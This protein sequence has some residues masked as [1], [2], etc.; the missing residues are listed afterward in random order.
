MAIPLLQ[1]V[2]GL[3]EGLT[4]REVGVIGAII[5]FIV[6][7]RFDDLKKAVAWIFSVFV[8]DVADRREAMQKDKS[9]E[10][11]LELNRWEFQA[12]KEAT[13]E[14]REWSVSQQAIQLLQGQLDFYRTEFQNMLRVQ[15]ELL[16]AFVAMQRDIDATKDQM[17]QMWGLL[18]EIKDN[19]KNAKS[20]D[21]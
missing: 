9:Q 5:I 1:T 18:A 2:D 11:E 10:I 13:K 20:R 19:L 21:L 4:W 17:R 3:F 15:Q 16:V 6:V 7:V 12:Q 8:A 14:S